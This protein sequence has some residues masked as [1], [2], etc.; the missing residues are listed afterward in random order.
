MIDING[1]R[2][3]VLFVMNK[4]GNG[5]TP[6]PAQFNTN[7]DYALSQW[8]SQKI[9]NPKQYQSGRPVP[10]QSVGIT[11]RIEDDLRHLKEV[12][13]FN[14]NSNSYAMQGYKGRVILPDGVIKDI[15]GNVAPKWM[16]FLRLEHEYVVSASNPT[17]YSIREIKLK[18]SNQIDGVRSSLIA[19]PSKKRPVCEYQNDY[20]QI[21]PTD[22]NK[23][24]LV[25]L[26]QP[27]TPVWAYTT[28][29]ARPVYDA[30]NSTDIDAPYLNRNEIANL[31]LMAQGVHLADGMLAQYASQWDAQKG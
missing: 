29:N 27:A 19:P 17:Q 16:Y 12:R 22:V 13:T 7:V 4:N 31:F 11:N 24:N 26:R 30:T 14:I 8:T 18:T 10:P 9:G 1:F 28:V 23:V 21:Y 5:E 25:Y 2:D 3:F 6:T 15:N 20:F